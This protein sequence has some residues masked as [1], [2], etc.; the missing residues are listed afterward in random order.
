MFTMHMLHMT[1]HSHE[2]GLLPS[3]GTL[4]AKASI[5]APRGN[6]QYATHPLMLLNT[7]KLH[8]SS[9]LHVGSCCVIDC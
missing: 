7:P 3:Q 8:S 2:S 4:P 5:P 6:H 1:R 9:S